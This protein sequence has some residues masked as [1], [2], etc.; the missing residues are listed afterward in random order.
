MKEI[1]SYEVFSVH[2]FS[3]REIK[4]IWKAHDEF[5]KAYDNWDSL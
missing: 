4:N 5:E 2:D 3:K 1:N